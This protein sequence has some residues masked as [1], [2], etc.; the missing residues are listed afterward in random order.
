MVPFALKT[1][2]ENVAADAVIKSA[3]A[4][5]SKMPWAKNAQK[6]AWV[7]RRIAGLLHEAG[8]LARNLT[9]EAVP[10]QLDRLLDRFVQDL[11]A[12]GVTEDDAKQ[13]RESVSKEVQVHVL[14]P[15]ADLGRT[16]RRLETLESETEELRRS[17]NRTETEFRRA[18]TSVR[19]LERTLATLR[20]VAFVALALAIVAA[21]LTVL[22][23]TRR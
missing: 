6:V 2:L 17:L 18:E 14:N 22:L 9:P 8:E 3:K 21:L 23:I 13:I 10:M 4:V 11:V 16:Q 15:L 19:D 5:W 12:E 20:A 7:E 1:L